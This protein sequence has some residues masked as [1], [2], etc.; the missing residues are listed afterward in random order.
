[1]AINNIPVVLD[2]FS[3]AGG[4]G[5]GFR[6]AGYKI[7]GAIELN[8]YAAETYEK[9][10]NVKV[11]QANIRNINPKKFREELKLKREELDVLVGCPPCQGFSKMRNDSGVNHQDNDL[12]LKYLEFVSEFMP[13]FAVFE[14]VP[15]VVRKV[16]GRFF[17]DQL[18]KGLDKLGYQR[19]E[20]I[21]NV[22][23]YGVPQ[24]R[25]RMIMIAGLNIET[26]SF[27]KATHRKSDKINSD[28]DL[29]PWLTVRDAI[30]NNR[31]PS[32]E[33]GED[34][35]Q[36]GKYPNHIA[37]KRMDRILELIKMIPKSG[38]FPTLTWKGISSKVGEPK[39]IEEDVVPNFVSSVRESLCRMLTRAVL[40]L[41]TIIIFCNFNCIA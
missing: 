27:P 24:C 28:R 7:V 11:K 23:D 30:G 33:A 10:L 39:Y 32:I 16:H 14:N 22:A 29:K 12:V 6:Q 40:P 34:G 1:M 15:G 9:N 38:D 17:Y 13:R 31:Y 26:L 5:L 21:V 25:K 18:C 20:E 4:T 3:G 8:Q 35:Q 37:G 19:I 41:N 2:I 36:G